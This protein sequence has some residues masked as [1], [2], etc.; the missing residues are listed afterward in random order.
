MG[1]FPAQ[2]RTPSERSGPRHDVARDRRGRAAGTNNRASHLHRRSSLTPHAR[3]AR[4]HV[5]MSPCEPRTDRPGWHSQRHCCFCLGKPVPIAQLND[6]SFFGP[7]GSHRVS[8]PHHRSFV[9]ESSCYIVPKVGGREWRGE[10]TQSFGVSPTCARRVTEDVVRDSEQPRPHSV[11]SHIHASAPT[12]GLHKDN[13]GD[14]L[15]N[16]PRRR[17]PETVVVDGICVTLVQLLESIRIPTRDERPQRH[18]RLLVRHGHIRSMSA[19]GPTA[20]KPG[21]RSGPKIRLAG[22]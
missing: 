1:V 6:F 14:F 5:G 20:P 13:V 17:G 2:R 22:V 7:E 9:V 18:V 4:T 19:G 8:D 12:P 10:P 11:S 21:S 16:R 15:G 3:Q